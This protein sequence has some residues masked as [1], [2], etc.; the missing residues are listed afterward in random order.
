MKKLFLFLIAICF[1]IGSASYTEALYIN[2]NFSTDPFS[3]GWETNNDSRYYWDSTNRWLHTE[4][5]TNSGDFALLPIDYNGEY[6]SLTYDVQIR[7][8]T[9]GDVNVGLFGST[10][11][12]NS[13]TDV[14]PDVYAYAMVGGYGGQIY[15]DARNTAQDVFNSGAGSDLMTDQPLEWYTVWISYQDAVTQDALDYMVRLTYPDAGDDEIL[16][17]GSFY[18]PHASGSFDA[19]EY[20]GVSMVGTWVTTGRYEAANIDNIT[21]MTQPYGADP[22]PEPATM[23]LLGSGIIGLAGFRRKFRK[24]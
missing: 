20:L 16:L 17:S 19:L 10:K 24:A 4:N 18:M 13:P 7:E 2:E 12:R 1:L 5:Y 8:R 9:T 15:V 23:L 11:S 3:N 14:E 22:V 6:F 21:F